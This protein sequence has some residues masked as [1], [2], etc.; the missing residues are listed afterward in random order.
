MSDKKRAEWKPE[1]AVRFDPKWK[2]EKQTCP[3]CGFTGTVDPYFGVRII[4][5]A[6]RKQSW[7]VQCRMNPNA[8]QQS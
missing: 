4:D 7:C 8:P 5:G 1:G 6:E 3:N 2:S